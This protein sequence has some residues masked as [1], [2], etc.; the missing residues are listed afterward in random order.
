MIVENNPL[1]IFSGI[2]RSNIWTFR[3]IIWNIAATVQ[4]FCSVL[5][6]LLSVPVQDCERLCLPFVYFCLQDILIKRFYDFVLKYIWRWQPN[7][8]FV[9]LGT[10][11]LNVVPLAYITKHGLQLLYFKKENNVIKVPNVNISFLSDHLYKFLA[12]MKYDCVFIFVIK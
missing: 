7:N 10:A 3:C 1:R 4:D 11:K 8:Y 12:D 9:V 6:S 5:W 2:M